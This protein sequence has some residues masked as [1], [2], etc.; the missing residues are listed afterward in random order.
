M[1]DHFTRILKVTD[2]TV[3]SE[4]SYN[5]VAKKLRISFIRT[6]S[7]WEYEGVWPADFARLACAYSIGEVFNELIRNKY[8]CTRIDPIPV[9]RIPAK[10]KEI[11]S[12]FDF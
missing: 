11:A 6:D 5:F 9:K 8:D 12:R 1:T 4:V 2:S 3:I 10:K 7:I